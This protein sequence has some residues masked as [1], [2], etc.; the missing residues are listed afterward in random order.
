MFISIVDAT[1][2]HMTHRCFAHRT[3]L[4]DAC[5]SFFVNTGHINRGTLC[6]GALDPEDGSQLCV[7]GGFAMTLSTKSR[8]E[9]TVPMLVAG[10]FTNGTALH[11]DGAVPKLSII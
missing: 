10:N 4:A 3:R 5:L 6:G 1:H 2:T 11:K 8:A 7:E 9:T